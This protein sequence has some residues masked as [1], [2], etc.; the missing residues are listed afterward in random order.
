M[1]IPGRHAGPRQI[2]ANDRTFFVSS[3]IWEKRNLL[4][5]IRSAELFMNVLYGYRQQ[6][7]IRL[8]EFV[9]MP[10]HFHLLITIGS[11]ISIERAVQLVKGGFAFRAA[12]E[13]GLRPPVW[14]KGFSESRVTDEHGFAEV[15]NYIRQNP[16]ARHLV[17][18]PEE[19]P[20][21]SAW[22][23]QELDPP[24]QRLKPV[25]FTSAVGTPEGVP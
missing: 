10:E 6:G 3:S 4:Q 22:P 14:Q 2:V 24:P 19:Y 23:G 11:S 5:S 13:L 17:A 15:R 21:S 9:V 12:R 25:E 8:H 1:S 20:F 18:R 16:V 7:K